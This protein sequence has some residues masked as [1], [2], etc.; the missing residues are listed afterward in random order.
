MLAHIQPVEAHASPCVCLGC[1]VQVS[2]EERPKVLKAS[3][4]SPAQHHTR[5]G[6]PGRKVGLEGDVPVA[7]GHAGSQAFKGPAAVIVS[8]VHAARRE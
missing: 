4:C 1:T 5:A 2:A 7:H 8:A 6:V 3:I